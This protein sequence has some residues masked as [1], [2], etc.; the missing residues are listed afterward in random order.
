MRISGALFEVGLGQSTTS[1]LFPVQALGER[2]F[3]FCRAVGYY[4]GCR[5]TDVHFRRPCDSTLFLLFCILLNL[6][7]VLYFESSEFVFVPKGRLLLYA[8]SLF[9]S[10]VSGNILFLSKQFSLLLS[11][12]VGFK[13]LLWVF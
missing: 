13:L 8:R 2:I 11:L 5:T 7:L 12:S 4:A 9:I 3:I 10:I 6:L 1:L